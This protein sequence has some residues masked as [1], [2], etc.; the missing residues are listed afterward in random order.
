MNINTTKFRS[1]ARRIT[2]GA[3]LVEATDLAMRM[4]NPRKIFFLLPEALDQSDHVSDNEKLAQDMDSAFEPA[5]TLEVE[6]DVLVDNI[7]DA[8][9]S[10]SDA[11]VDDVF[12]SND[13]LSNTTPASKRR[14]AT[15]KKR[16]KRVNTFKWTKT[17]DIITYFLL[18]GFKNG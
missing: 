4:Q 14:K 11:A 17:K 12:D 16:Q 2:R 6:E 10:T 3:T 13:D 1:S 7:S 9:A 5:R 8:S 15:S 18:F